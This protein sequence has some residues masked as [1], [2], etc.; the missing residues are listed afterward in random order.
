M[1]SLP[2]VPTSVWRKV[3]ASS[4][5]KRYEPPYW[6]VG[7]LK[8]SNAMEVY[9]LYA[10][11]LWGNRVVSKA[12]CIPGQRVPDGTAQVERHALPPVHPGMYLAAR[13]EQCKSVYDDAVRIPSSIYLSLS[14]MHASTL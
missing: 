6:H 2:R 10:M 8:I 12:R 14:L 3:A 9:Q 1:N 5:V 11:V 7:F 13:D 4:T